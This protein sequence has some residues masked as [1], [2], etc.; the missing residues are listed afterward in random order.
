MIDERIDSRIRYTETFEGT[1]PWT[2]R[3]CAL[4]EDGNEEP[5]SRLALVS[6]D[7]RF[8]ETSVPA[9]GFAGVQ[10]LPQHRGKGYIATLMRRA[11][12]GA[13]GRVNAAFLF[14]I[15]GLYGKYGFTSC[16]RESSLTVWTGRTRSLEPPAGYLAGNAAAADIPAV[17]ALYNAAHRFRPWTAVRSPEAAERLSRESP[18]RPAPEIVVVRRGGEM[19]GYAA[20]AGKNYGDRSRDYTVMEAAAADPGA[21]RALLVEIGRRCRERELS[22]FTVAEPPDGVVGRAAARLG[23]SEK[24][25]SSPD[26][27]GMAAVL[28]RK[29]LVGELTGELVRRCEAVH[30]RIGAVPGAPSPSRRARIIERLADGDLVAEDTDLI[31]LL[32]GYWSWDDAEE[33]GLRV[34]DADAP[35]LRTLFPGSVPWLPVPYSHRF[36]RY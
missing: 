9:E 34:S 7:I 5:V 21:G 26:G 4:R 36:D 11:L 8:G 13:A 19:A 12:A 10:T 16:L 14:G 24:W 22:E 18:W 20:V 1:S 27:G 3:I 33:A 15:E 29:S 2:R 6:L 23:C 30:E 35:I 31:R 28:N 32:L 17:I 25:E